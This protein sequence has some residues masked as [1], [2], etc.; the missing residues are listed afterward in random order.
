MH[1]KAYKNSNSYDDYIEILQ[2]ELQS[3][4]NEEQEEEAKNCYYELQYKY[5]Q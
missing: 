1:L 3:E 5:S 2:E 4:L